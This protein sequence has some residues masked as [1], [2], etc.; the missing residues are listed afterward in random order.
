M[1]EKDAEEAYLEW[2]K[3]LSP[4]EQTEANDR[5]GDGRQTRLHPPG[6]MAVVGRLAKW[7]EPWVASDGPLFCDG[8]GD[9]RQKS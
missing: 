4:A 3:T 2:I 7:V 1:K 6:K 9:F 5:N 8:M